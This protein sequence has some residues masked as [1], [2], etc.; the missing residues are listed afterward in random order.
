MTAT[1][2][3]P[4]DPRW[5][6]VASAV[7]QRTAGRLDF[8]VDRLDDV[9]LATEELI[10]CLIDEADP[11]RLDVM[12]GERDGASLVVTVRA[13]G[14]RTALSPERWSSCVAGSVSRSLA[15]EVDIERLPDQVR[16]V[17]TGR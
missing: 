8:D 4:A 9:M 14:W 1:V 3:L 17:F 10:A 7:I 2:D 6:P 15:S 5:A 16:L 12:V 11:D 13:E